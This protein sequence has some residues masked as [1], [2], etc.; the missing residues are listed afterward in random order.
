MD[1]VKKISTGSGSPAVKADFCSIDTTSCVSL[2]VCGAPPNPTHSSQY[3]LQVPYSDDHDGYGFTIE[4]DERKVVRV[5]AVSSTGP[6]GQAGMRPGQQ[7]LWI[8][9]VDASQRKALDHCCKEM[10][11]AQ[12]HKTALE[13]YVQRDAAE[14]C[15]LTPGSRPLGF[16]IKGNHPVVVVRVDKGTE[17]THTHTL[18]TC[19]Y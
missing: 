3:C 4:E 12:E 1:E 8:N 5:G 7:V 18:H 16:Q 17:H 15:V 19:T 2:L 9:G 10:S 14:E 11:Q 13:V 6:A